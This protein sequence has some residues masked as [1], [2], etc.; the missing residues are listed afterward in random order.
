[1]NPYPYGES[2]WMTNYMDFDRPQSTEEMLEDLKK[3]L[4]DPAHLNLV[5]QDQD[6]R[7]DELEDTIYKLKAPLM[8]KI[9]WKLATLINKL[10][11]IRI[12]W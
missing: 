6:K 12:E 2:K 10:P 4:N 5:I 8:L 3:K 11:K 7:I 1:M 9:K